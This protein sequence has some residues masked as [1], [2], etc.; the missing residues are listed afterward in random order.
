MLLFDDFMAN[1]LICMRKPIRL[2]LSFVGTLLVSEI[3]KTTGRHM[4][5]IFGNISKHETTTI[6]NQKLLN[7]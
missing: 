2:F 4:E 7:T 1:S 6:R 5:I 3:K